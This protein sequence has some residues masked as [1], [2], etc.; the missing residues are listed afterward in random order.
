MTATD[1]DR[2][3]LARTLWGEA[4]GETLAGQIAVAWIIR[5]RV[6]DGK[7]RSWWGEGYVG[8]CQK[9]YQSSFWNKNDPN[10]PFLSSA[11]PIPAGQLAQAQRVPDQVIAGVVP[12]PAGGATTT[13]LHIQGSGLGGEG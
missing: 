9:P 5:N 10:S 6:N 11:K 1:N 2:D 8:I 13:R 4:R 12:D 3:I 7:D